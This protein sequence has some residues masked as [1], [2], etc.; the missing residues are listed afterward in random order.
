MIVEDGQFA[1]ITLDHCIEDPDNTDDQMIWSVN[2]QSALDVTVNNRIA[3]ISPK[4]T[5]WNGVEQIQFIAKDPQGLEDSHMASFTVYPLPDPPVMIEI[6]SQTIYNDSRFRAIHLDDYVADPDNTDD[7]ITWTCN[8]QKDLIVT[9][10]NRV[11]SISLPNELWTGQE[12]LNFTATDPTGLPGIQTSIFKVLDRMGIY[13]FNGNGMIDLKDLIIVLQ[14]ITG[15]HPYDFT[16]IQEK[17][18]KIEDAL[19]IIQNLD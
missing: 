11:A 18:M 16:M 3:S 17:P 10:H 14:I 4:D 13:D 19:L 5:E 8:G 7:E 9:I 2:G 6:P 15:V 12:Y 1:K